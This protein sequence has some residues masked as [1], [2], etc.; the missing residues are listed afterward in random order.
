MILI[1]RTADASAATGHRCRLL[2]AVLAF[3]I[4]GTAAA[5]TWRDLTVAP[6]HRCSAYDKKG[7]YP[8]PQSIEREIVLEL[9]AVYG[10]YTGTCFVS[11]RGSGFIVRASEWRA[12]RSRG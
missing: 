5:E 4:A 11:S 6:E 8:Y 2:V 1:G 3:A 10:P 12:A 7:D 9:G